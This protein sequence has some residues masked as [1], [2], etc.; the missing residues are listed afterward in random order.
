MKL[1]LRIKGIYIY[2]AIIIAAQL[3]FFR[4]MAGTLSF[5]DVGMFAQ[6]ISICL[7]GAA[8]IRFGCHTSI[9]N[10]LLESGVPEE[11]RKRVALAFVTRALGVSLPPLLALFV[12]LFFAGRAEI[13][14]LLAFVYAVNLSF[15]FVERAL[16]EF[17][18]MSLMDPGSGYLILMFGLHLGGVWQVHSLEHALLSLLAIEAAKTLLYL[19]FS[20]GALN[21]GKVERR[22]LSLQ[23]RS[24]YFANDFLSILTSNGMHVYFPF[25]FGAEFAGKFFL[26]QRIAFPLQFLLNVK[27]AIWVSKY[28]KS[29][30]EKKVK[31]YLQGFGSLLKEGAGLSALLLAAHIPILA[32]FE[33]SDLAIAYGL[34]LAGYFFNLATGPSAPLFNVFGAPK[35]NL[36]SNL[37]AFTS[38]ALGAW[39][40]NAMFDVTMTGVCALFALSIL[41]RNALVYLFVRRVLHS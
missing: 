19:G 7:I 38:L 6:T 11:A 35:F 27:N 13:I 8:V 31:I 26:L 5:S 40:M 30:E 24:K 2:R 22:F 9:S 33:I 20:F 37:F 28:L 39:G 17:R 41:L 3:V 23:N 12:A 10:V 29:G 1:L 32:F 21:L 18:L 15:S 34:V 25:L 36:Y 14:F 16:G 4:E